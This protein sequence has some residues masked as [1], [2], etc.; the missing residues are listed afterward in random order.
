[1]PRGWHPHVIYG[2]YPSILT[3]SGY[4]GASFLFGQPQAALLT[5]QDTDRTRMPWVKQRSLEELKRW[6]HD[7]FPRLGLKATMM[8]FSAEEWLLELNG[9][10]RTARAVGWLCDQLDTHKE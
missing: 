6:K 1:M 4:V 2:T 7:P 3:A 5:G 9:A 10:G 8:T